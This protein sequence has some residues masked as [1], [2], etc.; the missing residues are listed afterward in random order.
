MSAA[1]STIAIDATI[2]DVIGDTG[3][4]PSP[5]VPAIAELGTVGQW[6]LIVYGSGESRSAR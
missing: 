4:P 1:L 5:H 6:Q 3:K 2:L